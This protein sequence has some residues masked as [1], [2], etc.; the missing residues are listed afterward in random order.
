MKEAKDANAQIPGGTGTRRQQDERERGLE[1]TFADEI[2]LVT[3]DHGA[4]HAPSEFGSSG[5]GHSMHADEHRQS[6]LVR[7][8]KH[9]D[10]AVAGRSGFVDAGGGARLG[11]G[12]EPMESAVNRLGS[13]GSGAD[14]HPTQQLG[15]ARRGWCGGEEKVSADQ[16]CGCNAPS[17]TEADHLRGIK[18][19]PPP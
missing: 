8:V 12:G 5:A 1:G 3:V 18:R 7:R 16:F 4:Q 13:P 6:R 17:P 14:N 10:V 9:Q 19:R 11:E 2:L 15:S